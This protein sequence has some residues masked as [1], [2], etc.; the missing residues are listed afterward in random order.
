MRTLL[1]STNGRR[2]EEEDVGRL[3]VTR[4]ELRVVLQ[5]LLVT[6]FRIVANQSPV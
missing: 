2:R 6:L 1:A 3:R 4:D 5:S